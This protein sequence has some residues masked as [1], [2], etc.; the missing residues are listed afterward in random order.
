MTD[1]T[2]DG[3]SPDRE[4]ATGVPPAEL[5]DQALEHH[6]ESL[7]R[8]K[9]DLEEHGAPQAE[10]HHEARTRELLDEQQRRAAEER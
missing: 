4:M 10:S 7:D 9:A 1:S 2:S 6:L 8:T 5:D 3:T